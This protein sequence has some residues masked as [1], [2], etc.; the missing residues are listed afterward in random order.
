MGDND[1]LLPDFVRLIYRY[2]R[3][4]TLL[5]VLTYS[6][7]DEDYSRNVACELMLI[8]TFLVH[9]LNRLINGI[10]YNVTQSVKFR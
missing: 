6:V 8:S 2:F 5:N 7:P 4:I 9:N 10:F 1:T 3:I